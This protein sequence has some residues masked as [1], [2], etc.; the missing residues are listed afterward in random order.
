MAKMASEH[1]FRASQRTYKKKL[2][3]WG[4]W[5]NLPLPVAQFIV[6]KNRQREGKPTDFILFDKP[7]SLEKVEE[8]V[9]RSKGSA[10]A[11]SS[12]LIMRTPTGLSYGS[13][14]RLIDMT[15]SPMP[16]LALNQLRT[17]SL[18][19]STSTPNFP[20]LSW[21]EN[22]IEEAEAYG[23]KT[24]THTSAATPFASL[25]RMPVPSIQNLPHDGRASTST[26]STIYSTVESELEFL[27]TQLTETSTV[28]SLMM[29]EPKILATMETCKQNLARLHIQLLEAAKLLMKLSDFVSKRMDTEV[30]SSQMRQVHEHSESACLTVLQERAGSLDLDTV[31]EIIAI[32]DKLIDLRDNRAT[33]TVQRLLELLSCRVD[34][35]FVEKHPLIVIIYVHVTHMYASR[36]E[37]DEMKRWFESALSRSMALLDARCTVRR[38]LEYIFKAGNVTDI[39]DLIKETVKDLVKEYS[40]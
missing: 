18:E 26:P 31:R 19:P 11:T 29:L 22:V 34:E 40:L 17:P 35:D 36:D 27:E 2:D 16:G 20:P 12:D 4:L 30:A 33:S 28:D 9:R 1:N 8:A 21:R 39:D 37:N 13:P 10:L 14:G 3:E 7:V 23:L 38:R 15:T 6:E 32:V 25:P 5:K 24:R